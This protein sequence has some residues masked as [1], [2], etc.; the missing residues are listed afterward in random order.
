[1][2]LQHHLFLFHCARKTMKL[3]NNSISAIKFIS[4]FHYTQFWKETRWT[5]QLCSS[6]RA[7]FPHL[8]VKSFRSA[9]ITNLYF[10]VSLRFK[11]WI[12][13]STNLITIMLKIAG[14]AR[15]LLIFLYILL[16][17]SYC[18]KS[19]KIVSKIS[20]FYLYSHI[21]NAVHWKAITLLPSH[22]FLE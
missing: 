8:V 21:R 12:V 16:P 3:L 19:V 17:M 20:N 2:N 10:L 14:E 7:Y 1:M 13:L 22:I 4:L 18:S 15:N 11:V 6:Y 9:V 5:L